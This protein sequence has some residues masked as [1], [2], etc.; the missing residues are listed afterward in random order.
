[1]V[2]SFADEVGV[3]CPPCAGRGC[4]VC[5]GTGVTTPTDT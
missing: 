3:A 2:V 5:D 4:D 1:M